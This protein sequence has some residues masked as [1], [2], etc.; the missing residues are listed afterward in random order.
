MP[1]QVQSVPFP[2]LPERQMIGPAVRS[3]V[4]APNALFFEIVRHFGH[5]FPV[6]CE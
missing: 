3:R 1:V 5:C 4:V 2:F 6:N